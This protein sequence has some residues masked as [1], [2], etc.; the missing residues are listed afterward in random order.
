[1]VAAL[2]RLLAYS[3]AMPISRRGFLFTATGATAAAALVAPTVLTKSAT[4]APD[5]WKAVRSLF[6]LDPNWVHASL[7]FLASH[8]KPVRDAVDA[9]RAQLD[10]DPL[11]TV[12][13]ALFRDESQSLPLRAR[14]A[15]ASFIGGSAADIAL[16]SNTTTGITLLYQGL[17]LRTGDEIVLTEHD[18]EVHHSAA[19]YAAARSGATVRKVALFRPHDASQVTVEGLVTKLRDAIGPKTRVLGIT[20]VH[21]SSGLKLPLREIASAV[22]S[23]NAKRAAAERVLLFVDGVHG[24]GS[25]KREIVETGIDGFAAG[26]HK[27]MM[28]PRGTG[29]VWAKPEVWAGLQPLIPS[30]SSFELFQAWI[31]GRAPKGPANAG[32]FEPGGFQAYEHQWGIGAAFAF[33]DSIGHDRVVKRIETLNGLA[34][35]ELAAMTH[36]HLRTPM[37]PALSAGIIAF[38]VDGLTPEKVVERL[39]EKRILATT[40]PYAVTYPRLAFGI[41]NDER[42]VERAVEA[43][44]G[45]KA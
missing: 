31:E 2:T 16:T 44:R 10:R 11:N 45:L 1:L 22:Q 3:C 25:T 32:W 6:N 4:P 33:H 43:V 37:S 27:W 39:R 13:N 28:A 41:A 20:W 29:F 21:S 40:S 34:K 26:L 23:V 42:D 8:P 35:K 9:Y 18:H 36:V 17:S 15:V 7:F 12:E 24:M 5:D 30:F 14:Q 19:E 38:E